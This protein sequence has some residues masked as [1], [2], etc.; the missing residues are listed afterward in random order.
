V[1]PNPSLKKMSSCANAILAF[2]AILLVGCDEAVRLSYSTKA[3]AE[4]DSP[5]ARG[6]LPEIIPDSSREIT[7]KND[8][9][10]NLSEGKFAFDSADHDKFVSHLVRIP[11]HDETQS[12]FY[13]YGEW[14]FW[15][16]DSQ[17]RC[18]FRFMMAK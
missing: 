4:A 17:D 16:D 9:D 18:G 2:T 8:L 1:R 6:W 12:K 5:F 10:L 15:I 3:E 14:G 13:E 7:M 11:G